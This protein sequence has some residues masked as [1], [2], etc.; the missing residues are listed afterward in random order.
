MELR[1]EEF[2]NDGYMPDKYRKD[3]QNVS[4]PVSWSGE[5][6]GTKSFA[7]SLVDVDANNFIHWEVINIPAEVH[8]LEEGASHFLKLPVEADE[9]A[10]SFGSIG[11]GGPMPPMGSGS[12][13]YVFTLYALSVKQLEPFSDGPLSH[14]IGG[15]VL[16]TTTLTTIAERKAA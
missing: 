16:A 5:P 10:N 3:I 6:E 12:H 7:L 9:L 15:K 8:S 13:R 2:E 1:S 11:Y 4:P 14:L